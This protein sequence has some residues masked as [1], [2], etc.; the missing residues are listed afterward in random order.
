VPNI[1]IAVPS[2]K[3]KLP[4][5][6]THPELAKEA[7]GWDASL[8][9][10]GS[11]KRFDWI[12]P[13]GHRYQASVSHR[14][15]SGSNC[16]FCSGNKVLI[17]FNDLATLNPE[18]GKEADGWD[19]TKVSRGSSKKMN[20]ICSKNH[21]WIATVTSRT[22]GKTGCPYCKNKKILKNFNDLAT[23]HPQIAAEAHGWDPT[24]IVAGNSVERAWKC[25][26]GHIWKISSHLRTKNAAGCPVCINRRTITGVNDL[27]T[28]HPRLIL[29]LNQELPTGVV[30]GSHQ[31]LSWKCPKGHIYRASVKSRAIKE[32]GCGVCAN[33]QSEKYTG[34]LSQTHPEIA[35]E[36]FGW[37]PDT[38]TA[39]SAKRLS[40]LCPLGHNYITAVSTRVNSS[41]GCLICSGRKVLTG[42]N[43]LQTKHPDIAA[44]ARGWDPSLVSPGSS[45]KKRQWQCNKGHSYEAT[46]KTR[47]TGQTGCA[48]CS[49]QKCLP[50]FNDMKT[51]HPELA[52]S[53]DGWD[54]TKV[55]AGTGKRL[56]WKCEFGHT[57]YATGN[58]RAKKDMT[59]CPGCTKFGYDPNQRGFL[60]FLEHPTWE[61]YQVGITNSFEK[62]M[63]KH[64]L[65]GWEVIEVR[66]PMDGH[67]TQEWETAILRMLKAKGADLSNEKVAGKFDGY[68]EAWSK[69]TFEVSSIKELMTLTEEFEGN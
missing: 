35:K 66:G 23:T 8:V 22:S 62:R 6:V 42:F 9:F 20:W 13:L 33:N 63:G 43:D 32:T 25:S 26:L 10:A 27:A 69:S 53:A 37:N 40:W 44:E 17:G 56:K 46:V 5:S 68:S 34:P 51:T 16:P 59:G 3:E 4:L 28:T 52:K 45:A 67:S 1:L 38:E 31:K 24:S 47:V 49:N 50:G 19:P 2:K 14:S 54:P 12:C 41:Q 48:Y 30:A 65:I 39:G 57:W 15:N 36:A 18:I 61:M 60:Y 29:E 21:K 58:D 64:K 7:D 11:G 55:T